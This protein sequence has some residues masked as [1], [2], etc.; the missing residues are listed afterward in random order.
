MNE[1]VFSE[2]IPELLSNHFRY[3]NEGSG[4]SVD[5][6]RERGYR[7]LLGK[8]ELEKL[9]FS[10][11]QRHTPGILIPLWGVDGN[12]IVSYQFRP[13]SP[14]LNNKGKPIKYETPM[15]ATNR[16]DCP[17]VCQ[18]LLVDP[19]VP[20]WITEGVKKGDALASQ[21]ECVIDLTGIWNWRAKNKLGGITVS[22]DFDSI[23]LNDRQVYIAFDSDYTTNPSVSQAAK[24]LA[25]FLK[26]KKANVSIVLLP[27]GNNGTKTG[28]DD[29]LAGGHTIAELKALLVPAEEME[30]ENQADEVFASHFNLYGLWL[31]V[32]KLDGGYAFAHLNGS[33][34][35]ALSSEAV[36]GKL[37]LMPRRLPEVDRQPLSIVGLPD[38]SIQEA[39]L[40]KP[41]E[42]YD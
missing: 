32:K 1:T 18:K 41:V 20:L 29:F 16:I 13:D 33:G 38:E 22:S 24:R 35:V 7:S 11:S 2:I 23:A 5:M 15:G 9:G 3:L 30:E 25:G 37:R 34:G 36:S 4:I 40:L 6:I 14:R 12:G 21:G 26:G 28:V 31:E 8:S 17:S 42:L 39:R 27:P 19:N 10:P